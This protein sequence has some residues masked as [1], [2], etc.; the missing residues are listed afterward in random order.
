M[1]QSPT[2]LGKTVMMAHMAKEAVARGKR[3]YFLVHRQELMSQSSRTF[4]KFE[5]PHGCIAPDYSPSREL[6]QVAMAQTL[7]RRLDKCP[8]PDLVIVDECHHSPSNTWR[9]ILTEY[10]KAYL[11][12]LT[13]TPERLDGQGLGDQYDAMVQGP[14]VAWLI[15]N[16]FLSPYTVFAPPMMTDLSAIRSRAGDFANEELAEIMDKPTIIGNAVGHYLKHEMDPVVK[17][18]MCP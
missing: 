2:G 15:E 7:V 18:I 10:E 8:A 1:L 12:G 5:I 4:D 13:A 6:V 11:V 9:R 3:T 14:S 17:T 16:Q